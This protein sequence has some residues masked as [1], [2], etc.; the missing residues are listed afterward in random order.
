MACKPF[1][2]GDIFNS[3]TA[4]R[5]AR[6]G[7]FANG[8]MCESRPGAVLSLRSGADGAL[9]LDRLGS[10]PR[11]PLTS[12]AECM[13]N[14]SSDAGAQSR[15]ADRRWHATGAAAY[16]LRARELPTIDCLR[17]MFDYEGDVQRCRAQRPG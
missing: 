3:P 1:A 17:F 13:P 5:F 16:L 11:T 14:M 7:G 9:G 10:A 8:V 12:R 2:N 15:R 6:S 4:F